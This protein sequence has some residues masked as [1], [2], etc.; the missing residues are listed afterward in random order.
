M[1]LERFALTFQV[2]T[3]YYI[4]QDLHTKRIVEM[5]GWKPSH[6]SNLLILQT[7]EGIL[8]KS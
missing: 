8:R 7:K 5:K 2:N 4:I 3:A 1:R 6:A